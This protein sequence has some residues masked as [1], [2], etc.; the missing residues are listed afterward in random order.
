MDMADDE[1]IDAVFER[2][3]ACPQLQT[4]VSLDLSSYCPGMHGMESIL[5]SPHLVNL[6]R[7]DAAENEA[8]PTVEEVACQTFARITWINFRNSDS[9]SDCPNIAPIINCSHLANLE[10]LDF[11]EN[12]QLDDALHSLSTTQHMAR[13]RYLSLSVSQF[14][15]EGIRQLAHARNL[16]ALS[17]LDLSHTFGEF[18]L[19]REPGTGDCYLAELLREPLA[20]Q[21]TH[22]WLVG[23]AIS[24]VGALALANSPRSLRL[25]HLD[26]TNNPIS[27]SGLAALQDRFGQSA[28][29]LRE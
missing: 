8:G 29:I 9:A 12:E 20:D 23:N 27:D 10:H 25:E 28:C 7:L 15:P 11:G 24:D 26:V 2:F 5:R 14:T 19:T 22:L 1:E 17:E 16:P 4:C 21:L 13:L 18:G 3:A 6:R